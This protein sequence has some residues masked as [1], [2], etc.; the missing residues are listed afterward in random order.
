[1]PL[2]LASPYFTAGGHRLIL[3][4]LPLP[5]FDQRD[6]TTITQ[7]LA[8]GLERVVRGAPEQWHLLQ[9]NWPS[10]PGYRGVAAASMSS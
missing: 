8:S 4:E 1:V 2:I 3:E 7:V 6:L 9:A 5:P 10:D